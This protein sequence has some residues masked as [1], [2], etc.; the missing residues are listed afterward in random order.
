LS[1][2]RALWGRVHELKEAEAEWHRMYT[3]SQAARLGSAWA[4]RPGS[5]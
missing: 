4:A 2:E 1:V 5:M 3:S